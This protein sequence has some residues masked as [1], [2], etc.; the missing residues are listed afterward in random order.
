[1][2]KEEIRENFGLS[3]TCEHTVED[4][5]NSID[6]AMEAYKNQE[7]VGKDERIKELE[8]LT[9]RQFEYMQ[10][11]DGEVGAL[12]GLLRDLVDEKDWEKYLCKP[13]NQNKQS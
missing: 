11:T 6:E 12:K 8:A 2:N 5:I 3:K 9:K 7:C 13:N 4:R 10:E 1:M